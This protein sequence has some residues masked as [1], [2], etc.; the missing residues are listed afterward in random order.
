MK[1]ICSQE[2][3]LSRKS[4][5]L[6]K[7]N[8]FDPGMVQIADSPRPTRLLSPCLPEGYETPHTA[9]GCRTHAHARVH[10]RTCTHAHTHACTH[11]HYLRQRNRWPGCCWVE[12]CPCTGQSEAPCC[13]GR[14]ASTWHPEA[15]PRDASA[16]SVWPLPLF[17]SV[18][19]H[20]VS[21]ENTFRC[22]E[23]VFQVA[24]AQNKELVS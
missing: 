15:P 8:N 16:G 5:I 11:T 20:K 14:A 12:P 6:R 23:A 3:I 1:S 13:G 10:T 17:S 22:P 9:L 2:M 4:A 19:K 21:G 7:E 24:R 18:W